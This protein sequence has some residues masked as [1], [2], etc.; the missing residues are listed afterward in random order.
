MQSLMR[1][2]GIAL[3]LGGIVVLGYHGFFTYS[4]HEKIAQIGDVQVTAETDKTVYFPPLFGGLAVAAG[5]VF[6]L[7]TKK[8]K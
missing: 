2:L 5:I 7:I 8:P 1:I 6:L 4:T 3:I